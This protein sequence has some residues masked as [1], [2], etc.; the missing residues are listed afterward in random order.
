MVR[1]WN[2]ETLSHIKNFKGH[3]STVTVSDIVILLCTNILEQGLAFQNG[4]YELFSCSSD[5]TVKLWNLDEMVYV[6][7]L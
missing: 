6:E 2:A 7:T 3:R 1:V 4:T 5:R